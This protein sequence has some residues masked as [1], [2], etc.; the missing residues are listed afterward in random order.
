M[1]KGLHANGL[2]A[3]ST[4]G[5]LAA[6]R[7]ALALSLL[8]VAA[9]SFLPDARL[10][11]VNHLAFY[12]VWIR[13]AA[14]AAIALAFLPRAGRA[15]DKV[16]DRFSGALSGR[17][18]LL[19]ALIAAA[20]ALVLF[21]VFASATE[22][23]GDGLYTANNIERASKVDRDVFVKVLK[24]PDPIYPGTEMLNLTVSRFAFAKLGI[25][26]LRTVRVMNALLGAILVFVVVAG[27]RPPKSPARGIGAPLAAI[28]FLSGGIQIFF[29]Y[30]EAYAPLMF[31]AGLYVWAAHRTLV[32]GASLLG[33]VI[34]AAAAVWM[35]LLGLLL[36]P[37]LVLLVFWVSFGRNFSG[38][39]FHAS[40][41]LAAATA[42]VP[43]LVVDVAGLQRFF[44]PLTGG[45]Y[46][47]LSLPH[48]ADVVNEVLLLFPGMIVLGIAAVMVLIQTFGPELR[49]RKDGVF[50]AF[51]RVDSERPLLP[52]V[53]FFAALLAIPSRL[54]LLFF[55]PELGVA[56][57]W[58]LFAVTGIGPLLFVTTVLRSGDTRTPAGR[59]VTSLLPPV[60]VMSAVLTAAWIG[61]N[62]D[63]Q[64]AAVRF[65]SILSYDTAR[66]GYAY[67]SLASLYKDRD[68]ET[69]EIHALEKAVDASPNPRYLFTLG[70]RYF[71]AGEREKAVA[72]LDR[73]LR[74]RPKHDRAR[75]SLVQMLYTMERDE[76]VVRVC[77]EGAQLDSTQGYYPFFMGKVYARRGRA[78]EARAALDACRALDPPP[79][80]VRE[81]DEILRA[82]D[83]SGETRPG[84][85]A[86][87]EERTP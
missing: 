86:G 82:L 12:P 74:M 38:R 42:A 64:R 85:G 78:A 27:A 40:W 26:P 36:V 32:R 77:K 49:A 50:D 61:V 35:H 80:I 17:K 54:F 2:P 65:E 73:C 16:F 84:D 39:F 45:A 51:A 10:W 5:W 69:A 21:I 30:I 46:A 79:E 70:L 56:R 15:V 72:T 43:F 34:F 58:D 62:A 24:D 18:R 52:V 6:A 47:V 48:L 67:E 37:S 44:L 28:V 11:G 57:D 87:K 81:I 55:K 25:P 8:L 20:A 75:Q 14:L 19:S 31:F 33:P 71:H 4:R 66:A 41:I 83:S 23:L 13:V 7:V 3:S 68:D 1:V 60:L 22:L 59:A 9:A 76:E 63:P 29:G 53:L